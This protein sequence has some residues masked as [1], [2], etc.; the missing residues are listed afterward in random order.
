MAFAMTDAW[1][2]HWQ[3]RDER[4]EDQLEGIMF[5]D[6]ADAATYRKQCGTSWHDMFTH[7]EVQQ[8]NAI[9]GH[10]TKTVVWRCLGSCGGLGDRLRGILT[11]FS[12]A[13]VTGRAFFID[14]PSPAPLKDFFR[15]AQPGLSWSFEQSM[16]QG[17]SVL[18]ESFLNHVAPPLG[19]YSE[20]NLTLYDAYDVIIQ[21]NN[22]WRPFDVLQNPGVNFADSLLSLEQHV[23]AGCV[24]NY[25]LVPVADLQDEIEQLKKTV[26]VTDQRILA[27]Q[28]RTGDGQIKNKS[29]LEELLKHYTACVEQLQSGTNTTYRVFLTTDS[30]E[31]VHDMRI[32]DPDVLTLI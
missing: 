21:S 32:V 9:S 16:L 19:S 11:S 25:L 8:K 31:V 10:A 24:L 23:L 26:T 13:L 14:H 29:W 20:A 12:L 30:E 18:E 3:R 6:K 15:L 27:V 22:F 4:V 17:R 1:R 28:V 7:W 2:L 5:R